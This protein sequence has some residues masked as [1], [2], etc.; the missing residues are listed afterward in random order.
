MTHCLRQ[1]EQHYFLYQ[2]YK[3]CDA[4]ISRIAHT[5]KILTIIK[6]KLFAKYYLSMSDYCCACCS[7][8]LY[9]IRSITKCIDCRE[10]VERSEE[11]P[12]SHK[13]EFFMTEARMT[14]STTVEFSW[15]KKTPCSHPDN[16]PIH[17]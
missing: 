16:A 8:L 14:I 4:C 3:L 12:S 11:S 10:E 17:G 7:K 2:N 13:E 9:N 5:T 15:L 6:T 1:T